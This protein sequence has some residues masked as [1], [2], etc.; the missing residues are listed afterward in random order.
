MQFWKVNFSLE[1]FKKK[2]SKYHDTFSE[3][4]FPIKIISSSN[5]HLYTG[6]VSSRASLTSCGEG[7][8]LVLVDHPSSDGDHF[9]R[10]DVSPWRYRNRCFLVALCCGMVTFLVVWI[11]LRSMGV[12]CCGRWVLSVIN[13]TS[14]TGVSWT[15]N[16][17]FYF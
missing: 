17:P 1:M 5:F 15:H 11:F 7:A 9:L 8:S 6:L 13:I 12:I 16:L 3:I 2:K 14:R 4:L 10:P